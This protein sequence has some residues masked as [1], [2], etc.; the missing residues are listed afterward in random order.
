MTRTAV[1]PALL[2]LAAAALIGGLLPSA[3]AAETLSDS[4]VAESWTLPNGL[5]VATRSIPRAPIVIAIVAYPLGFEDDPP[6]REG[7][8][9]LMAEVAFMAPAGDIPGRTRRELD[10]LRPRGWNIHVARRFTHLAEAATPAQFPGVLRQVAT[11]MA[12][13][14]VSDDLV[15]AARTRVASELRRD[16]ATRPDLALY[17]RLAQMAVGDPRR[18]A[19]AWS[20]PRSL[21][22]IATREVDEAIRRTYVPAN[23]VLSLAGDFRGINVRALVD[24]EFGSLPAGTR[25]TPPARPD[26]LSAAARTETRSG[27]DH[28]VGGIG[29]IA[30]ALTDSLHPSFFLSALVLGAQCGKLWGEPASPLTSRFQYS[31]LEEPDLVRFYPD[32]FADQEDPDHL[33]RTLA[34]MTYAVGQMNIPFDTVVRIKNSVLWLLGGP[35]PPDLL[36]QVQSTSGVLYNVCSSQATRTLWGGEAFWADYR[37]R[38]DPYTS[39]NLDFWAGYV[40]NPARQVRLIFKPKR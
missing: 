15:R 29:I 10:S 26:T 7:L 25:M 37:K 39:Q 18:A 27:I 8:A 1:R 17:Y 4:T 33:S 5:R 2:L 34:T 11:R 36:G 35:L 13:V 12:G 23:A 14:T 24:R 19:D 9:H 21:E 40:V 38:F 3:A 22:A 16:F 30:P 31:I 6:G 32:V 28:P 20:D